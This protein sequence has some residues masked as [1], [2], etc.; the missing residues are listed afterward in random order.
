ME[1][2]LYK[3]FNT[4]GAMEEGTIGAS[5]GGDAANALRLRGFSIISLTKKHRKR[6][7]DAAS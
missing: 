2:Y 6:K 1:T 3:V 4:E 5:S 7:K